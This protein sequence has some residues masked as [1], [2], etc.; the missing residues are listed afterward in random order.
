M[1][2]QERNAGFE[3]DKLA[4]HMAKA[5]TISYGQALKKV[6]AQH[7]KLWASYAGFVEPGAKPYGQLTGRQK[8]MLELVN[9]STKTKRLAA[10]TVDVYSKCWVGID[11][12][13]PDP[14][15]VLGVVPGG[16][17]EGVA[18]ES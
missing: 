6:S 2:N 4:Q 1:N 7:P 10:Q 15:G 12:S 9:D 3:L 8:A 13:R 16:C 17:S 14:A 11:D 5:E 18:G